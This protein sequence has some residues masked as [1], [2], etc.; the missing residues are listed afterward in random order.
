[1]IPLRSSRTWLCLA[2]GSPLCSP[3]TFLA[4]KIDAQQEQGACKASESLILIDLLLLISP[5]ENNFSH[6]HV[7]IRQTQGMDGGTDGWIY[8]WIDG[9]MDASMGG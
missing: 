9:Q 6:S 5:S 8:G 4:S 1:M 3:Q 7:F 2:E